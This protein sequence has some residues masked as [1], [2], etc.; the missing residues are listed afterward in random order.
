[1]LVFGVSNIY[2]WF[3]EFLYSPTDQGIQGLFSIW[4]I[5]SV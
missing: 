3:L 2:I 5:N 1:M 4:L